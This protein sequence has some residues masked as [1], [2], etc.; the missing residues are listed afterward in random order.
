MIEKKKRIVLSVIFIILVILIIATTCIY[1]VSKQ[2]S[3]KNIITVENEFL[4]DT[5]NIYQVEKK[6]NDGKVMTVEY[7]TLSVEIKKDKKINVCR[8]NINIREFN[9]KE[10]EYTYNASNSIIEFSSN[11]TLLNGRFAV[12]R[13]SNDTVQFRTLDSNQEAIRINLVKTK[14][15]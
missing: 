13:L 1:I 4:C 14:G 5:W 11:E 7:E 10:I 8:F 6:D 3:N 2:K 15:V 9:C 12:S